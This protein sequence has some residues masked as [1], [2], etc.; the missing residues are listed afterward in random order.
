MN[1]VSIELV[2]AVLE[3]YGGIIETRLVLN[4]SKGEVVDFLRQIK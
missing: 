4:D 1:S 3:S 2:E